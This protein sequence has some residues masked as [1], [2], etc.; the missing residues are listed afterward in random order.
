M[1]NGF[2][3]LYKTSEI[4]SNQ[5]LSILKKRLKQNNVS[6]KVGHLGTLDPI[7]EGVLPVALGRATRLFDYTLDKVKSYEATFEFGKETDTLDRS[8]KVIK[9]GKSLINAEEINSV[10]P[11]LTGEIMQL[12]PAY[13]AKNI[14][15]ERAYKIAREGG[16]PALTPKKVTIYNIEL[17]NQTGESSYRFKI[18]CGGGTYIRSIVRDMAYLLGTVGTMTELLRTASGAFSID[19][20][21]KITEDTDIN[22][23]ILPINYVLSDFEKMI[24]DEKQYYK[25]KNGLD[26]DY[27]TELNYV[28]VYTPE[29]ELMGIGQIKENKLKLK[30][31]LL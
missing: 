15:G 14:N 17:L 12:P 28:C 20:A 2:I 1:L 7:A 11:K 8:G 30:T 22:K 19:N 31:W 9:V 10:L 26:I 23:H 4:T 3:N 25:L 13:S 18:D 5:A 24:L 21:V 6:T 29:D 27:K 16:E